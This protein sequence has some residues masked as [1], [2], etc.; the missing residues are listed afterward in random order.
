[1]FDIE[2]GIETISWYYK[3]ITN[4]VSFINLHLLC[5]KQNRNDILFWVNQVRM[6]LVFSGDIYEGI[7]I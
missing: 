7:Y 5:K 3:N 1:V 4:D 6:T 2:Q